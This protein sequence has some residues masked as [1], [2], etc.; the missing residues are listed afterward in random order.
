MPRPFVFVPV[1]AAIAAVFASCGS[2]P[3]PTLSYPSTPIPA[4]S[5]SRSTPTPAPSSVYS[6]AARERDGRAGGKTPSAGDA[7]DTT[8]FENY[9]VNPFVSTEDDRFST[10]AMDV[11][12]ASYTIARAYVRDGNMPPMDGVRVE[13]FINYFDQGYP[14][15]NDAFA[16]HLDGARHAFG[17]DNKHLLR[18]GIQGRYID[19]DDRRDAVLTFVI[20]TSGSMGREDRLG[21]AKQSLLIL[22]DQLRREDRV[23][24][25]SYG[26]SAKVV[27]EPTSNQR[28]IRQAVESLESGGSTNAEDGLTVGYDMAS[29]WFEEGKTNRVILI[30]DGVANVGRTG[31]DAILRKIERFANENVTLSAIGVGLANY[32][33]VL[34]EQLAN[35]GNGNYFY[36][37]TI[38]EANELLGN[39]L[40]GLLEVIA[41]DAKIQVEFNPDVVERFRLIGYENRA[42]ETPDFADDSV[43]A[44]E[45]GAGHSVTALYELR[46]RDEA[47][48][49]VGTVKVRYLDPA[50]HEIVE[51]GETIDVRDIDRRFEDADGRFR[52]TASVAEFAELLRESYWAQGGSFRAVLDEAQSALSACETTPRDEEFIDFVKSVRSLGR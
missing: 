5:V 47:Y 41:S 27:L 42:L 15:S 34:M 25:V 19:E 3:T 50:E 12:T 17:E 52:F 36:L 11:D 23:G 10:F 49:E 40:P 38:E 32:N 39:G 4:Q 21:L 6:Q 31:P 2:D 9:G 37:D 48:G 33:D 14:D 45:V 26:S 16:I 35:D 24:I 18:V 8:F 29:E 43:D 28:A 30:S 20:D 13:E 22:L 7:Y 51:L 44:G 1:L 46:L